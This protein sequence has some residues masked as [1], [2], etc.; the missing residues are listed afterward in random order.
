M[1]ESVEWVRPPV[2]NRTLCVY[3]VMGLGKSTCCADAVLEIHRRTG[4]KARVVNADGGGTSEAFRALIDADIA[5]IWHIDTWDS[6]SIFHYLKQATTGWWPADVNTPNSDL[7]PPWREY[8]VCQACGGN[9]GATAAKAV[10]KCASC[11]RAIQVG[12]PL[13]L[14]REFV[15]G[16][17]DVSCY[18]F[19]GVTSFGEALMNRVTEV[20]PEGG[21][22]VLDCGFKISGAGQSHYNMA[23]KYL[24]NAIASAARLPVELVMWT[25]LEGKGEEGKRIYGP[26]GPGRKLAETLGQ[27]FHHLLH[28]DAVEDSANGAPVK[29]KEGMKQFSRKLFLQTHFPADVPNTQFMA[30]TSTPK[31]SGMPQVIDASMREFFKLLDE[32]SQKA[33]ANVATS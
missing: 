27:R 13:P 17:E 6:Q 21:N 15:N 8:R 11:E 16:F 18:V 25:A 28:L 29:S 4:K 33:R 9:S 31:G 12:T 3:G 10:A 20:N 14:R 30:K 24:G 23:Q 32:A 7:L 5:E 26:L 1:P 19:E 22:T 2:A